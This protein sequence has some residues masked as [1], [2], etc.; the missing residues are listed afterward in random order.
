MKKEV[1][2]LTMSSK[3]KKYC[4][5][6]IDTCS[7]EWVRLVSND[8][9]SHGALSKKDVEYKDR[10]YCQ[11][12]DV[13]KISII[14]EAPLKYQPENVLINTEKWWEK[15]GEFTIDDLLELHPPKVTLIY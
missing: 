4:I 6:G 1:V 8:E 11:P 5:A 10:T 12:L 9:E 3:N 13:V 2:I 7:G 14:E 15:I